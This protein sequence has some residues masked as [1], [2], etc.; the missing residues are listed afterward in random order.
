MKEINIDVTHEKLF[1]KKP[2]LAFSDRINYPFGKK[3]LEK[4]ISNFLEWIISL[5][6]YVI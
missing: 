6:M 3:K 4:N 5:K 1:L 2:L